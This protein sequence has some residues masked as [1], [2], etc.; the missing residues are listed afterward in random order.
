MNNEVLPRRMLTADTSR[1]LEANILN[2]QK[3]QTNY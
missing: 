1:A 3:S 2:S